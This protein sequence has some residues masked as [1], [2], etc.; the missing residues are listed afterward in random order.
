MKFLKIVSMV[1][2]IIEIIGVLVYGLCVIG[3]WNMVLGCSRCGN[4]ERLWWV[5][6]LCYLVRVVVVLVLSGRLVIWWFFWWV[7]DCIFGVVWGWL[8]GGVLL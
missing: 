8:W 2:R 4:L 3:E 6:S 7:L 1:F 5:I